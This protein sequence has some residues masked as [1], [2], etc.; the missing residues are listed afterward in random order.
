[1]LMHC[2]PRQTEG[3]SHSS[4]SGNR[5]GDSPEVFPLQRWEGWVQERCCSTCSRLC[6]GDPC[7]GSPPSPIGPSIPLKQ[8]SALASQASA[9]IIMG[10][11]LSLSEHDRVI[12]VDQAAQGQAWREGGCAGVH[13]CVHVCVHLY[14]RGLQ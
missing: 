14:E 11:V 8:R 10:K 5:Q 13:M 2:C 12:L 9:Q 6:P 1:M 7:Q 4:R 3:C